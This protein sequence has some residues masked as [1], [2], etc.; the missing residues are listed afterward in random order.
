MLC[1]T[2]WT[3]LAPVAAS[4]YSSTAGTSCWKWVSTVHHVDLS[5][6]FGFW[7][8][9]LPAGPSTRD[10]GRVRSSEVPR[11]RMPYAHHQRPAPVLQASTDPSC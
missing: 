2:Q 7:L 4:T 6:R 10:A 9:P 5:S 3:C 1:P 11:A 8:R